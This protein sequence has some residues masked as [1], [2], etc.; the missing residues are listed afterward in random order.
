MNELVSKL[1]YPKKNNKV[2]NIFIERIKKKDMNVLINWMDERK[3]KF[4][5]IGWCYLY[6][7][8]DVED[9]FQTT[10]IKV[11]EN[12]S[13]LKEEKYFETWITSIFI[14]ECKKIIRNK[15]RD[16]SF[17]NI[18]QVN[19]SYEDD[20]NFEFKEQLDKLED[21]HKEIIVLKYISGYSQEEIS[22]LLGIPVGTV[23]SRIYRAIKALKNEMNKE[24]L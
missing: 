15:K 21:I 5:K 10:I 16:I 3:D 20:T 22:E 2:K 7:Q 13:Q 18:E 8:Y 23:K 24:G 6:N 12:I 9:V 4:Y 11:Y 1:I 17:N 19:T 14:N